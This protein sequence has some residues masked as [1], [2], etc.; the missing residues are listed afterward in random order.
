MNTRLNGLGKDFANFLRED[1]FAFCFANNAQGRAQLQAH[2]DI[3]EDLKN[4]V[5]NVWGETPTVADCETKPLPKMSA[6]E[7]IAQLRNKKQQTE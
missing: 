4:E 3:S 5:F 6:Q 7:Y 1:N 2:E